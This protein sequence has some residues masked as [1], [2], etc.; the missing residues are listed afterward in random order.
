MEP[1]YTPA[2]LAEVHAYHAPIYAAA[3]VELVVMPLVLAV[4]ATFGVKWLYRLAPSG[5]ERPSVLTRIW[6][7]GTWKK[8]LSFSLL[9]FL[10]LALLDLPKSIWFGYVRE[11]EFGLATGSL[12]TF[13]IDSLK[14]HAM[15]FLAVTALTFGLFGIARRTKHWW[16]LVGLAAALVMVVSTALDPY[17]ARLYVDQTPLEAG[18]LRDGIT[19][20]L[21]R[22][23]VPFSDVLVVQTGSRTVRVQA[24]FAG[25]GPTRTILLTDTLLTAMNEKEVLAAIAHESGHVHESRWVG[26]VLSPLAIFALLGALEFIFRRSV[27]RGWY[28]ITQRGDVRVLPTLVLIFQLALMAIG[29]VTSAFAR[30]RESA[31]DLYALQLT[32]DAESL[33]SLLRKLGKINKVDPDPPRWYVL[34][35]VT[36]PTIAERIA[37]IQKN[38]TPPPITPV[39]VGTSVQQAPGVMR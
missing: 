39:N 3:V 24:A 16:W 22:A 18:E 34:S 17:R 36:H 1:P 12:G 33:T 25:T 4:L 6:G 7:D 19:A 26:R 10:L 30:E 5:V 27:K 8:A 28:G 2:E 15:L 20:L 11:K 9:Y 21:K 38:A 13:V 23:E 37:A 29:P 35:G 14:A 32:G 31:A